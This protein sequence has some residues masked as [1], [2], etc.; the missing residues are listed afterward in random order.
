MSATAEQVA[1]GQAI[2]TWRVLRFYDFF[3]LGV[4][5]RFVWKC[6][7]PRLLEHYERYVSANHLDVGVGTGYFLDR[8]RFPSPR[9]RIVLLDANVN[10]LQFAA[11]RIARYEPQT[12]LRNVFLPLA[13]GS[14][15]FDSVALNYLLHCVPGSFRS[16]A[17]IFDR[18][19]PLMNERAVI[20]GAT[21]LPDPALSPLGRALMALYNRK[22]IFANQRD[23]LDGLER[24][25]QRRF[26][27]VS[28]HLVGCAALFSA[29]A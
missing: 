14:G 16:K 20:F 12:Y 8:C 26:S 23:T 3:V 4:S 27:D 17:M 13:P 29:R 7:T 19:R 25:L 9:P 21:L 28:V 22:G 18:L 15:A 1:A 11:R 10:A 5:N 6:P 2:Y 24:E